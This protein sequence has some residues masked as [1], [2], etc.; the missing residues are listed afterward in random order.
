MD[1]PQASGEEIQSVILKNT[2]P[3]F[4]GKLM[5]LQN[6]KGAGLN[7]VYAWQAWDDAY[8]AIG[9]MQRDTLEGI[10]AGLLR[11]TEFSK[12]ESLCM[13]PLKQ[14]LQWVTERPYSQNEKVQALIR[15]VRLKLKKEQTT[16]ELEKKENEDQPDFNETYWGRVISQ[17]VGWLEGLMDPGDAVRRRKTANQV[18][19]DLAGERISLARASEVLKKLIS[20]QKGGWLMA[21]IFKK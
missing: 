8:Q 12:F 19:E 6:I 3:G 1:Q 15:T 2:P 18:Y 11:L 7:Y 14:A 17:L 20:R 21:K 10:E 16:P 9:S 5:G 13:E 4:L